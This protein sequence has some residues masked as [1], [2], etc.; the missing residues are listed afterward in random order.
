VADNGIDITGLVFACAS[1]PEN[2]PTRAI[3]LRAGGASRVVELTL[4]AEWNGD[5]EVSQPNLTYT[6]CTMSGDIVYTLTNTKTVTKEFPT[7][8]FFYPVPPPG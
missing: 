8:Q 1:K 5:F 3:D 4:N 6:P 2:M 7:L